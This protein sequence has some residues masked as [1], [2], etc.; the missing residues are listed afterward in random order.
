[1]EQSTSGRDITEL[2]TKELFEILSVEVGERV[3][4]ILR[5]NGV[6]GSG[7]LQ[8]TDDESKEIFPILGD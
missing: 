5:D 3:A 2:N 6:T 7:L 4:T 8:L 1:M